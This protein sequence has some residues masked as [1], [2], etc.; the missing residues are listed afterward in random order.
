[1]DSDYHGLPTPRSTLR[2]DDCAQVLVWCKRCQ[3]QTEADLRYA[4]LVES[5]DEDPITFDQIKV[6][7]NNV[8]VVFGSYSGTSQGKDGP[9]HSRGRWTW[10]ATEA[11]QRRGLEDRCEHGQHTT[12]SGQGR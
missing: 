8:I 3:H 11:S 1:M 4:K 5:F 7:S 9:V 6:V 12:I 10:T 2:N